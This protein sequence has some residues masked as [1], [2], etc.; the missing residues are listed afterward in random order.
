[1]SDFISHIVLK[2]PRQCDLMFKL[3]GLIGFDVHS[4]AV[5]PEAAAWQQE[6]R[7]NEQYKKG[8]RFGTIR[9]NSRSRYCAY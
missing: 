5:A 1:M 9:E 4:I 3:Q 6:H 8:R 7:E 2:K